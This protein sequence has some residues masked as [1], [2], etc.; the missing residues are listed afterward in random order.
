MLLLPPPPHHPRTTHP[1]HISYHPLSGL[2]PRRL[3]G[4]TVLLFY[5]ARQTRLDYIDTRTTIVLT[6]TDR[7]N[8][9]NVTRRKRKEIFYFYCGIKKKSLVGH[10][11][12]PSWLPLLRRYRLKTFYNELQ[13]DSYIL[14]PEGFQSIIIIHNTVQKNFNIFSEG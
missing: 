1:R 4:A 3:C 2:G 10:E 13:F 11:Y 14:L 6:K 8:A 9:V 7:G 5:N 12:S